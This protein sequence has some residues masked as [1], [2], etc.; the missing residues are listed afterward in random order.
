MQA[1]FVKFC[2]LTKINN[3]KTEIASESYFFTAIIFALQQTIILYCINAV[4][5]N[6]FFQAITVATSTK[7]ISFDITY[8]NAKWFKKRNC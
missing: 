8:S 3:A 7:Q 4:L 6:R 1:K 2:I 5:L